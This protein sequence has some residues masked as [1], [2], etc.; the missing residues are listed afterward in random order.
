MRRFAVALAL[1]VFGQIIWAEPPSEAPANS[2]EITLKGIARERIL[3]FDRGDRLKWSGYVSD[4]YLIATPYGAVRT[5][6]QEMDRFE[7]PLDG[8]RD[9]FRFENVKV[10]RDG[11]TAVMSYVID[12]YEF[13]DDQKYVIPKLRKTDTYVLRD[14]RWLLLASQ[15]TFVPAEYKQVSVDPAIYKQYAGRYQLMRSLNYDVSFDGNRLLL[16]EVG[17][18]DTKELLP[19]SEDT[20]FSKGAPAQY[21]FVKDAAGHVTHFLIRDNEYDIKVPR[22][23]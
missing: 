8:Y 3:Q 23:R 16:V 12:E 18:P 9:V 11:D 20:F 4:G 13:W 17:K 10:S 21:V 14:N 6:N 2:L 19:I 22:I 1:C 7:P 5:K 15:E